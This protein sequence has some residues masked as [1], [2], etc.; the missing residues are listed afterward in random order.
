MR[1]QPIRCSALDLCADRR[2]R[3]DGSRH[4]P[5]SIGLPFLSG[6]PALATAAVAGNCV[7]SFLTH[8]IALRTFA[9]PSLRWDRRLHRRL[10]SGSSLTAIR[11]TN[12][13]FV[14]PTAFFS[15]PEG[16]PSPRRAGGIVPKARRAC[17]PAGCAASSVGESNE[18][19]LGVVNHPVRSRFRRPRR[20][21]RDSP[22]PFDLS[23][24]RSIADALRGGD[25]GDGQHRVDF[26]N[27]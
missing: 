25:V 26:V 22:C 6:H 20:L 10:R 12:L 8:A 27:G 21:Q 2:S 17:V 11:S 9:H 5:L 23:K 13:L 19:R 7:G 16:A 4:E 18:F 14:V 24:D 1:R 15:R 3:S